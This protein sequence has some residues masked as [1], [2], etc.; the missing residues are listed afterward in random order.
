MNIEEF[1]IFVD[2]TLSE[3]KLYAELHLGKSLPNDF[4]FRWANNETSISYGKKNVVNE[5]TDKVYIT[6]DNIYPCVDLIAEK[7]TSDNRI[8]IYG[9]IAGYEPRKF[10]T[11]WSNRPGPFIYGLGSEFINKKVKT[12]S[13]EFKQLLFE[14]GLIH[15]K[16]S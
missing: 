5:I 7:L 16:V 15:Y 3:L 1:K 9:I 6:E 8:A 2:K 14:R 12:E 4:E 10:G 11:G 13:K